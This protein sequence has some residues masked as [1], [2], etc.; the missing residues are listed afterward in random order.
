LKKVFFPLLF[1]NFSHLPPGPH[2][3]LPRRGI[4]AGGTF[5]KT[6]LA[7]GH[8]GGP[9]VLKKRTRG[10][11]KGLGAKTPRNCKLVRGGENNIKK[12]KQ[13]FSNR[14]FSLGMKFGRNLK[15]IPVIFVKKRGKLIRPKWLNVK[16]RDFNFF[17]PNLFYGPPGPTIWGGR[18]RTK[19]KK[20]FP[21]MFFWPVFL[22]WKKTQKKLLA[23]GSLCFVVQAKRGGGEK[24]SRRGVFQGGGER[25]PFSGDLARKQLFPG[26]N[27]A[28]GAR[29]GEVG[30]KT[31]IRG[32][33]PLNSPGGPG[34]PKNPFFPWSFVTLL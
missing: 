6:P 32:G 5:P 12:Q 20:K 29:G 23:Q 8:G 21:Q 3:F 15:K 13:L 26:D 19:Q 2:F 27:R 7:L 34:S 25:G 28:P 30:D 10:K 24:F 33:G 22:M 1:Q 17:S 18:R 14:V 4:F 16:T 9:V 11:K 31:L